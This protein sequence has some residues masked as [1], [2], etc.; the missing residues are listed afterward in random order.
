MKIRKPDPLGHTQIITRQKNPFKPI[1]S[2]P[3]IELP[4]PYRSIA[5]QLEREKQAALLKEYGQ[6][7]KEFDPLKAEKIEI[8]AKELID[9]S[10]IGEELRKHNDKK[11]KVKKI[12]I[13][14]RD[15]K[16]PSMDDEQDFYEEEIKLAEDFQNIKEEVEAEKLKHQEELKLQEELEK[17]QTVKEELKLQEELSKKEEIEEISEVQEDELENQPPKEKKKKS[18]NQ[19]SVEIEE[20]S[21]D[22][23]EIIDEEPKVAKKSKKQLKME[24][25]E[26]KEQARIERLE[27]E[28][29]KKLAEAKAKIEEIKQKD[30]KQKDTKLKEIEKEKK[31]LQDFEESISKDDF[32]E[33]GIEIMSKTLIKK[34]KKATKHKLKMLKKLESAS[35]K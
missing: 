14:N 23:P 20:L 21:D 27:E 28:N 7:V 11:G 24:L 35:Y 15:I 12:K 10:Y 30:A 9:K 33:G 3:P 13:S 8:L 34:A 17:E 26:A 32:E 1:S 6:K 5:K 2:Q 31:E 22:E 29:Q 16:L 18:K 25:K 19:K 4:E